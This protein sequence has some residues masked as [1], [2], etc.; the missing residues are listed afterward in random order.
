MQTKTPATAR[1]VNL[2]YESTTAESGMDPQTHYLANRCGT[3]E[4]T[5][6][7]SNHRLS[8]KLSA[9][10]HNPKFRLAASPAFAASAKNMGEYAPIG[11]ECTLDGFLYEG[12]GQEFRYPHP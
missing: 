8:L 11:V 12:C 7:F 3:E 10:T 5:P 2:G 4:E 1:T 6:Q 9:T